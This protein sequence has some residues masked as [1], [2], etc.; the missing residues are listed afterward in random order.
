[1]NPKKWFV[2]FQGFPISKG[3]Q[4]DAY[5]AG[6]QAVEAYNDLTRCRASSR[7]KKGVER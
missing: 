4:G 3:S 6:L 2:M 1:M 5:R 7:A